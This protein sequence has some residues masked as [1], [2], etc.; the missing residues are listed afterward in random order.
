MVQREVADRFFAVPSTKAYGA[1]SVL[2]QL[3]ARRTGFHAVSRTVFRPPPNVDSALV[4]FRRVQPPPRFDEVRRVV[5]GAFAHRRKTLGNGLALAGIATR[6]R[7]VEALAAIGRGPSVRAEELE[8]LDV[9]GA[10]G[11]SAMNGV[12]AH[13]KLN[14]ALVVGPL[15]GDGKHE[16]ATLLQRVDLGDELSVEPAE[17][18]STCSDS[19]TTRS[20][21]PR[22]R[23]SPRRPA[24]TRCWC[25]RIREDDSGRRRAR[26]RQLERSL[27]AAARER[28]A[29]RAASS[30]QAR[31]DRGGDR[32]G[33]PV[34]PA[35]GPQ[36]GTGDGS[37]LAPVALPQEFWVT[38]VLPDGIQK[39]STADVYRRFDE[40]R[41]ATGF[42]QRRAALLEGVGAIRGAKDLAALPPNDLAASPAGC[43]SCLASAR[44]APMS[45]AAG[46]PSTACSSSG[47]TPRRPR[48]PCVRT[49]ERG[50]RGLSGSA[51]RADRDTA[52]VGRPPAE[53]GDRRT[54]LCRRRVRVA[55]ARPGT[56]N[57]PLPW[58]V[59]KR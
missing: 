14:L 48:A 56:L 24:S 12:L 37:T 53:S 40:R 16:V 32:R 55:A 13:A 42:E 11:G 20:F 35:S 36:L 58:G 23:P 6:D 31:S 45:A 34:L 2:V 1:V 29:R 18:A 39:L 43:A 57:V 10:R 44:F 5:E 19:T 9:R 47:G 33:R 59:A 41:G 26:R 27:G 49:G 17:A 52:C 8:P 22:S 51:L 21:E 15:R 30:R 38:L 3:S 46:R 25:A 4:A 54:A 50:S 7:A 28:A